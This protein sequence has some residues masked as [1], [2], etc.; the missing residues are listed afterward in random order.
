MSG[1]GEGWVARLNSIADP[2]SPA[3][4]LAQALRELATKARG[5][6]SLRAFATRIH[7]SSAAVSAALCGDPRQVPSL[8]V[9]QAIGHACDADES[10]LARLQALRTEAINSRSANP[11]QPDPVPSDPAP[12]ASTPDPMPDLAAGGQTGPTPADRPPSVSPWRRL[13]VRLRT[14][15]SWRKGVL[16]AVP[17]VLLVLVG[18]GLVWWLA[19]PH[20]CGAFSGMRLNNTTDSECIGV[21]DGSYLFNDPSKATRNNDRDTI[22]RIN[23]LEGKI[24]KENADVA[25]R[26]DRYVTVVLLMPLTVSTLTL[27]DPEDHPAAIPLTDILD[28]LEGS[29]TALQRAN[30]SRD[31]GDPSAVGLQLWLA[32]QGSRQDA[33][34]SFITSILGISQPDH[35][36][37]AVVGLG[38]SLLT[39]KDAAGQMAQRRI[40]M[41]GALA[42]AD[43]LTDLPL[44]WSVSPSNI[45]YVQ[46]LKAFLDDQHA[47]QHALRYGI[48][49]SDDNTDDLYAQSLA[50]DYH[51]YL[52][53]Y[54]P[55]SF[56]QGQQFRGGTLESPAAPDVFVPV[57]TSLCTAVDNTDTPLDMVF[58][59]GRVADFGP[60]AQALASR[61]CAN[62]PLTVLVG[63]T[64][65]AAAADYQT[66]LEKGNV[67]VV[68]A[69]SSDSASW[70]HPGPG[71]PP[72]YAAFLSAYRQLGF[73]DADLTDG[74]AICHH[75][76]L[77]TAAQAV[78]LAAQGRPTPTPQDVATQLGN[79]NLANA[80]P[81]ASGTLSFS[82]SGGRA[83]GQPIPIKRIP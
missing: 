49:V 44:L 1:P 77:V 57:V 30:H 34:P 71:A 55:A 23:T 15:W 13:W 3:G 75:D 50:K 22:E 82:S 36:V 80:V 28:S 32:N 8:E 26:T 11:S 58:Y 45:Q 74:Y 73:P 54:I 83:S 56:S 53:S 18:A 41:V 14:G 25:A 27:S 38:S 33:D 42:S 7:Y 51:H 70:N 61:T 76:A 48:V 64:G 43:S 16:V 37:V 81:A 20:E 9:I 72:G 62:R 40:P 6:D 12:P 2:D 65:F 10:T 39:N 47:L 63:A 31:F 29:Y 60:F 35:P 59:S 46:H 19:W 5:V 78:R 21:T 24:A 69:T 66:T 52:A 68:Y 4:Q 17:V 67:T 79:L